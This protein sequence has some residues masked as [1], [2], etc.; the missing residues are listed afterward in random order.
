MT[1]VPNLLHNQLASARP[2]ENPL[3]TTTDSTASAI[4]DTRHITLMR[5]TFDFP[6]RSLYSL[7]V[8]VDAPFLAQVSRRNKN[9]VPGS[10]HAQIVGTWGLVSYYAPAE[11]DPSDVYYPLGKDAIGLIIYSHDGY[12]STTMLRPGQ[13]SF[14]AGQPGAATQA[15]LAE[16]TRRFL[17][18]TGPFYIEQ[19]GE[20]VPTVKHRMSLTN[21]PNWLG[22][23]QR[24]LV[25]LDGDTLILGLEGFVELAG[26]RRKP[27]IEWK[28]MPPNDVSNA[29]TA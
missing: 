26:V 19:T 16:S 2:C 15:E 22:N 17:G 6:A 24:R 4:R 28:R 27:I 29:P 1:V 12:M 13:A 8:D 20:G 18:Y 14:H 7:S 11:S 25:K 21:F 5:E 10:L 23:L 3:S 9:M